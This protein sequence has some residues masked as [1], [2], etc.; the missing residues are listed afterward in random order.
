MSSLDRSDEVNDQVEDI[1]EMQK[2]SDLRPSLE[3]ATQEDSCSECFDN[4]NVDQRQM[5]SDSLLLEHESA[6]A[7]NNETD[8]PLEQSASPRVAKVDLSKSVRSSLLTKSLEERVPLED[9][10]QRGLVKPGVST[11]LSTRL[12]TLERKIKEDSVNHSLQRRPLLEDLVQRGIQSNPQLT[13][14][15]RSKAGDLEMKMKR[16]MMEKCI[17]QR[18]TPRELQKY[19]PGVYDSLSEEAKQANHLIEGSTMMRVHI[20]FLGATAEQLLKS[21]RITGEEYNELLKIVNSQTSEKKERL[22]HAVA[23]FTVTRDI[24]AYE[25]EI[26]N[27]MRN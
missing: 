17:Y 7:A 2:N 12:Q 5:V 23:S 26:L 20:S 3:S 8:S 19:H 13:P 24:D 21:R 10:I 18:P 16:H 4:M 14:A 27:V 15:L 1:K 25:K 11:M 22:I 9:L 6:E